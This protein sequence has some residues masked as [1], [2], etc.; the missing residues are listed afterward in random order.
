MFSITFPTILDSLTNPTGGQT[1]VAVDHA[2]QHSNANDAIE[3]LEAKVGINNSAVTTSFDYKL[4]GVATGDK[5]VSKTGIETITNKTFTAP[6]INV[7]SDTTGDMYYRKSDGTFA[8]LAIGTVGQIINADATGVPVWI[9]NPSAAN[10]S[11]TV[12]GVVEI[13]TDAEMNAG[14]SAGGT[15]ALLV[16]AATSAGPVGAGK[17]VQ[18]TAATKYP[19]A[20]GSLITNLQPDTYAITA[21]E[22]ITGQITMQVNL[23]TSASLTP[24]TTTNITFANRGDGSD[25]T[26]T[27]FTGTAPM[28][29]TGSGATTLAFSSSKSFRLRWPVAVSV[30]LGVGLKYGFGFANASTNIYDETSGS[31]GLS[32]MRFVI[33]NAGLFAVVSNGTTVTASADISSG[34]TLTQVNIYEIV[35]TNGVDVK[36]YVNGVLK[37]TLTTNIPTTSNALLAFG[38]TGVT[39]L[40]MNHPTFSR[41]I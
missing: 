33:N 29:G 23:P 36:F 10:A 3:A 18:F 38:T 2:L 6:V 27:A 19:A 8:R 28:A 20:D 1:F 26:G 31:S 15:S 40:T 41:A 17:I 24:W 5:A 34:L 13:A 21:N 12:K 30:A 16:I 39:G 37:S 4:S 11:T 35:S 22:T 25:Y 14:T 7:G 9:A 32:S